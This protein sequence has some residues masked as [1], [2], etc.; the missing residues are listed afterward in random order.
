VSVSGLPSSVVVGA[1]VLR[2]SQSS[3]VGANVDGGNEPIPASSVFDG[4]NE[5]AIDGEMDGSL[6][7]KSDGIKDGMSDGVSDG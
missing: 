6:D 5:G 7:G 3:F 4:D 1:S 2:V